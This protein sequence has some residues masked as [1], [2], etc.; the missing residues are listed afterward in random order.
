MRH[1]DEQDEFLEELEDRTLRPREMAMRPSGLR[2]RSG[3]ALAL[4]GLAIVLAA[5]VVVSLVDRVQRQLRRRHLPHPRRLLLSLLHRAIAV[6][7]FDWDENLS[8]EPIGAR[9]N[10]RREPARAQA[11]S[12]PETLAGRDP[13]WDRWP[14][15]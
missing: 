10:R 12:P 1:Q 13:L 14:D 15:G 4:P 11:P 2:H 8:G 7:D 6:L 9:P 5:W 3:Q